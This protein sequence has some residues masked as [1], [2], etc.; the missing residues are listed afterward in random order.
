MR[1]EKK[2]LIFIYYLEKKLTF[3]KRDID[4]FFSSRKQLSNSSQLGRFRTV[5]TRG[6]PNVSVNYAPH[7]R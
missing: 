4:F 7:K 6:L 5:F 1:N 3:L 2:M